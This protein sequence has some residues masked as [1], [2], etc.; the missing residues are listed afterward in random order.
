MNIAVGH[1]SRAGKDTF[2]TYICTKYG[3][4]QLSFAAPIYNIAAAVQGE[5]GV[6][7]VKDR[8]LL[9]WIGEGL[10]HIYTDLIWI[11]KVEAQVDMGGKIVISD[12]RLKSELEFV[13]GRGFVTVKISRRERGEMAN[14]THITE[15]D[16]CDDDFDYIIENNGTIQEFYAAIDD[17][18]KKI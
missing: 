6:E 4:N 13:R 14:S 15:N 11:K 18:M 8:R 1:Q 12:L 10:K 2:A 7:Q 16:L 3:Y 5:L 9:Q 17:F